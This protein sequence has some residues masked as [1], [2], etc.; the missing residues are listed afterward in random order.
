VE[1]EEVERIARLAALAVDEESLPLL[2]EQIT[3]II[4]YISQ[5]E[6]A[7]LPPATLAD[8]WLSAAPR[9]P[10]RPDTV[11]PADLARDLATIAPAMREGFFVVPRLPAMED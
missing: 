11:H 1:R 5:V 9:Q 7:H 10:L 2:A 3:R 6:A 8:F 4:E